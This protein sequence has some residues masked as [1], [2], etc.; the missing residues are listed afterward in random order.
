MATRERIMVANGIGMVK[1][2]FDER[3]YNVVNDE[4]VTECASHVFGGEISGYDLDRMDYGEV[5]LYYN[6][7]RTDEIKIRNAREEI[8]KFIESKSI[9]SVGH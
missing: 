9:R 3:I 5:V 1:I 2:F 6:P 8:V 7:I 4:M